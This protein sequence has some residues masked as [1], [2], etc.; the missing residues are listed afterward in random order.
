MIL[1]ALK[2]G[3]FFKFRHLDKIQSPP[4][5]SL[6]VGSVSDFTFNHILSEKMNGRQVSSE[7]AKDLASSEFEKRKGST[8]WDE[9]AGV[10]KNVT[11]KIVETFLSKVAP[12]IFPISVQESFT[13]ETE[14]YF[15]GGTLDYRQ[16]DGLIGDAKTAS[17]QRV[18]SY[19]VSYSLQPAMYWWAIEQITG[20]APTKFRFDIITR[21]TNKTPEYKPV[22]GIVTQNDIEDLFYAINRVNKMVQ[23]GIF[24]PAA[25]G[26]W[27]CSK[28]WCPFW[29]QCKGR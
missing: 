3:L 21:V 5:S 17:P 2:C 6:T 23:S 20:K 1:D 12:G 25:E 18:S 11:I 29:N 19:S 13:L 16:A 7:E 8:Q 24:L 4:N 9:D 26:A 15:L 28:K 27:W 14:N 10:M 22:E